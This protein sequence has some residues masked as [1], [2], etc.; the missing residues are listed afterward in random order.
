M[1]LPLHVLYLEDV[2]RDA[3]LVEDTLSAH[4]ITCQIRRVET[5]TD[6]LAALDEGG[7]EIILADYTVAGLDG[8]SAL[9]IAQERSPDVPFIFVS[10]TLSQ[11]LAIEALK[12]GATDCVA[13]SELPRLVPSLERA[14]REAR[15]RT[16]RIQA[17]V[18][19]QAHLR[20]LESL[21]EVNQAMAPMTWNRRRVR[22]L[23]SS[24]RPLAAIGPG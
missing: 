5:E 18:E 2:V 15:E 22:C 17:E 4:G 13:K 20:F 7:F 8:L 9:R 6:F 24:F 12:S 21:D 3:E 16:E 10:G 11:D 23:R 1:K 14:L 19:R